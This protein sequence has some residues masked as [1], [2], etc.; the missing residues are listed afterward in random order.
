VDPSRVFSFLRQAREVLGAIPGVRNLRVGKALSD[1]NPHPN[2]LV[3]E[4]EN[5]AAL[6][7]YQAHH[8]HQ[9]FL[10]EI[11]GSLV[12]GKIVYDYEC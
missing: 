2:C 5:Q 12:D 8:L 3:V 11:L 6:Q 10:K 9:R 1:E 7:E 4:F